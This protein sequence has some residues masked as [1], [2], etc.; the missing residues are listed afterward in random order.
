M[1]HLLLPV[2]DEGW[3]T[4]AEGNKVSFRNCIVIGTSNL[5]SQVLSERKRALGIGAQDE[6]FNQGEEYAEIMSE[7]KKYLRP[8]FINRLDEVVIFNRLG[9]TEL[10][11]VLTLQLN[12]LK[13]RAR[14]KG[15][16]LEIEEAVATY[17]LD[18][19]DTTQYGAR[20]IKRAVETY[21][22]NL[23]ASLILD[24]NLGEGSRI[25][26]KIQDGKVQVV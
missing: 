20:P 11:T 2:L 25:R 5:G 18:Q 3:L 10:Q 8:E 16:M 4:D 14:E 22:E 26:V 21:I 6:A 19:I 15:I 13:A 1:Y 24:Q 9:K 12:D 17:V 23:L 7:V